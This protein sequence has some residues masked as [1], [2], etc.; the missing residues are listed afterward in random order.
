MMK[1]AIAYFATLAAAIFILIELREFS[2]TT[3]LG[4]SSLVNVAWALGFILLGIVLRS[5]FAEKKRLPLLPYEKSNLT[6]QEHK[7]L[8]LITEGMSNLQIAQKLYISESTV[9]THVHH[10]FRKLNA[11]RRTEAIKIG[12]ELKIIR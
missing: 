3:V 6:N 7:V 4:T 9:K 1:Q 2:T 8:I 10:I 11:K 12:R 5:L